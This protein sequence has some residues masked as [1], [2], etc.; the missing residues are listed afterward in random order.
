MDEGAPKQNIVGKGF[1]LRENGGPGG[2]EAGDGLKKAVNVGLKKPQ[3][4]LNASAQVEGQGPEDPHQQP[5][6]GHGE[7]ALSGKE[8]VIALDVGQNQPH[9]RQQGD[10]R[11]EGHGVVPIEEAHQQGEYHGAGLHQEHLAR[12]LEHQPKIHCAAPISSR[13]SS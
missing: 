1:N 5:D 9:R 13:D 11:Q 7:K 12:E 8:V 6:E 10:G 3:L 4:R 2:G